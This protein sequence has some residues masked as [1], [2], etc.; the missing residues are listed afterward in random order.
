MDVSRLFIYYNGQVLSQRTLGVSDEGV[1]QKNIALGLRKYGV[2]EEKFWPYR[3]DKLNV[4]PP[5]DVYEKASRYTVVP[6]RVPCNVRAVQICL[7]NQVPVLVDLKL[8]ENAHDIIIAND[9]YLPIPDL[10]HTAAHRIGLHTVVIVG[11]DQ[12]TQHFTIRNS[13]GEEW[14]NISISVFLKIN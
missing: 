4:E 14:V 7:R 6:L 13:W 3:L 9:G 11:Y 2:C 12:S 5:P 1:E 10:T 8:V